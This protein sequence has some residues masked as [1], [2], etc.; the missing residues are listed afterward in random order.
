MSLINDLPPDQFTVDTLVE[1]DNLIGS[2]W[3]DPDMDLTKAFMVIDDEVIGLS[4]VDATSSPTTVTV[5]AGG[6]GRW[7]SDI[8]THAGRADIGT[9]G[10]GTAVNFFNTRDDGLFADEIAEQ[11][12]LD[13]RRGV[14]LGDWDFERI[15][16]HNVAAIMR[17]Q[18]RSTWKQ[19]GAPGGDTEG[20]SVVEVSYL[21][22]DGGTAV[23][24]G[25]E[26][27]DGPDGIR[28][29]WSDG[30][31]VQGDVTLL[32]NPAATMN[33]GFIQTLDDLGEW[34]V[35]ADFKPSAFMNN[36]NN[37]DPGFKNGTTIFIY[38]GGDSGTE[39]ARKTFRDGGT[40][41][42]RFVA[43]R[44]YWKN[45][46][47]GGNTGLQTPVSLLWNNS[48]QANQGVAGAGAGL[49]SLSVAGPS[50]PL[51]EH[52]GP[53]YPLQVL[54]FEKPFL[55][56]GGTLNDALVVTGIDGATQLE[57]FS[58]SGG[59]IPLGEGEIVLP[60]IDFD[61]PGD[62]WSKDANGNFQND[63]SALNFPVLRG[64]RTLWS[65]LT[66][67]GSDITGTSSEVYLILFGDD[68]KQPNNGAFKVIGAGTSVAGLT[69]NPASASNRV[70]VEFLT[71]GFDDFDNTTTKTVT[72]ELRSQTTNSEDG[73][74]SANGPAALTITM[75][76]ATA[77]DGGESN[78]WNEA[79][80]N[81]GLKVGRTLTQPFD[82]KAVLNMTL[83]YHPGRGATARVTDHI[84]TIAVQAPEAKI[85]RQ[86]RA[87]LDP[88]FPTA[89]GAPGNP[90]EVDYCP[91]HIQTW[92]RLPSLGLW[93]PFAPDYGGNVVLQSEIDRENESFFD[94]GSK[95]LL[96]RPFQKQNMTLPGITIITNLLDPATLPPANTAT[97]FGAAT[98]LNP[99]NGTQYPNPS[100][101]L[102][103]WDGP[104]DD[105]Q[106]FTVGLRMAYPVPQQYM[107]R[108]GRHDIPYF[109][110]NGPNYGGLNFLEGINH[111]FC[112]TTDL[113][114]PVFDCIGGEDNLTGG[115]QVTPLYIQTGDTS[116]LKYAQYG[117]I[118]GTVKRGYQGR[119][120]QA[121]GTGCAEAAEITAK[122]ANVIS[123]D[124][125][126]GLNGIMLPPYIGI[127]RVYGVYDRRDFVAKGG[128]TYQADR[129]TPE[130]NPTV[131]LMRRDA[132]KQTLFICEDGA[133]DLTGIAGDHTYIIPYNAIDITKSPNFASGEEPGDLEYVVEISCFGFAH[134]WINGN[135]Y[136]FARRHNG[137]G[138]LRAD[139]D[140]PELEGAFMCLPSAAPDSSQVY[141][142]TDRTVYQG[143]PY[144]SR[145]GETRTTTD[146][147]DR[148]GQI[149]NSDAVGLNN[150]IQQFDSDGEQIPG[151]PNARSFQV[152]ATL[153]FYTTMGTGN[154]GGRL[155]AG[156]PTDVGFTIDANPAYNR[157]PP[158]AD[159]PAW[160]ILTRTFTE[161]QAQENTSRAQA[162]LE[163]L[164][165]NLTFDF[166]VSA[167]TVKNPSGV[168]FVFTATNGATVAEDEFD[169]SSP[170]PATIARELFDKINARTG[171]QSVVIARND[172]DSTQI[173][174]IAWEVGTAGND[175]EVQI[176]DTLNF[177]LK[178][179]VTGIQ[180][181]Q[182]QLTNTNLQGGV[183]LPLNAGNGTTQL[184]LTG[185][186][187]RMPLG[188][189]LQDSDFIGENPL[190]DNAS[191]VQTV[192]GGIRPVQTLLPLTRSAGEEFTRSTGAPGE[193]LA[194]SDGSIL[195]Y[196]AFNESTNP[197]GARNFRLYRGGGSIMVLSGDNPGG[198]VDW[199]ADSLEPAFDPVLK[200]GLLAAR[201]FLVRN[202]VEEA[203]S[204]DDVTTEGDEIQ[205]ILL[206]NGIISNARPEQQE[207]GVT[208]GGINSP[209]GFGIGTTAVDRYRLNGKPMFWGRTRVT[210]DPE[211]I[212][213]APFPGR[214]DDA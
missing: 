98:V 8:V 56:L 48:N 57:G 68:E 210:P 2:G 181:L 77:L 106:I 140:N 118:T 190:Q 175:V 166:G 155:F 80:I 201:A 99:D 173:E 66:A 209:T 40:R 193:L 109:Q 195:Q 145:A 200:G 170:D 180:G 21:Q 31:A 11:D 91:T 159:T 69:T 33:A 58:L 186:T 114:N 198:P 50:E 32:L 4:A 116:G 105:A 133:M 139:T 199:F 67:G 93:S 65:M 64:E 87:F 55:V 12:I 46:E 174:I 22:Q 9:P 176:N 169:A 23:P 3:D 132:D 71:Q 103:G 78:L 97:L 206:T 151:R 187:D 86:S 113:T 111:L 72:A 142:S 19:A 154:V 137:Q 157:V 90:N 121:V 49:Q 124:F 171:L 61:T 108:F 144:M 37:T 136:V 95:S 188:I 161:G 127:A 123:S 202:F 150:A 92:N 163:V 60:G 213:M 149:S 183:D 53:M 89:T 141:V 41:A 197:G 131:N 182:S 1:V 148:Y 168:P 107:P 204:T 88:A 59:T 117:T 172:I 25:T 16:L 189:L 165:N 75:T 47:Q 82:Y 208:V 135:N 102:N 125:G 74:G 167:F 73:L 146:Y 20:V 79:N 115:A 15:L 104:K 43:P 120:T 205:L 17:N 162:V 45:N 30:A 76:D 192:L 143:D 196:T 85:L 7:G 122:L 100:I 119:L 184:V 185:M 29:I 207:E 110:D 42:V 128:E 54:D 203:F 39:G 38:I 178:V 194:Q 94:T 63:P 152:L 70:R 191:A 147:E 52:P 14:N 13:L 51:S 81:P 134:D 129:V 156:T 214:E 5:P 158:S 6:R 179:P 36:S 138:T 35:G 18:L 28:Q 211:T 24:V 177:L 212:P 84:N 26:A 126:A 44:E 153:D 164:G 10:S 96:F 130:A 27:V 101:I 160:R 83:M 34:D 112:D 62:W